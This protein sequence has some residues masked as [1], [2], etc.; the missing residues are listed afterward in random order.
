MDPKIGIERNISLISTPDGFTKPE[1]N[2]I[3]PYKDTEM[4]SRIRMIGII[5]SIVVR[6]SWFNWFPNFLM[7]SPKAEKARLNASLIA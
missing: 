5:R 7:K 4:A 6:N 3:T 1:S 2:T